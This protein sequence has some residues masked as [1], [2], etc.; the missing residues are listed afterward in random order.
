MMTVD[1][2]KRDE[3]GQ[4]ICKEFLESIPKRPDNKS[5]P[6]N[7]N[8]PELIQALRGWINE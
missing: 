2:V 3:E 5:A 8:E 1:L 4:S 6:N 7:D